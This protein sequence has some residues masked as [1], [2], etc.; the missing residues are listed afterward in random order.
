[1]KG[2]GASFERLQNL[3]EERFGKLLNGLM[4]GETAMG[5]ARMV[6]QQPPEGWGLFQD[7]AEKTLCQQLN[8]LRIAAANG[9][10]GAAEAKRVLAVGK[11][12]IDRLSHISVPVLARVEEVSEAQRTLV[13]V[14][15][16]KATAEKRTF[17]SVNDAVNNY[18]QTLLDVQKL[19]FD[20][21]LDEFKGPVGTTTIRGASQTTTYPDGTN[22]QK[23]VFEAVNTIEQIFNARR[24][25]YPVS[26]E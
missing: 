10:Y 16:E 13:L 22:V 17:T 14:L 15:L 21:G 7:V 4:R 3:G 6:Q 11:P 26:K 5:L 23:Q 19:R 25:P 18:R 1:M 8:R 24:I 2:K 12:N 20:L 9:M